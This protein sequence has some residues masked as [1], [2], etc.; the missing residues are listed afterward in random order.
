MSPSTDSPQDR[1]TPSDAL[2][3]VTGEHHL[4]PPVTLE[5]EPPSGV[6]SWEP[7]AGDFS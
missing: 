1:P 5:T 3:P 6:P 2:E 7:E 4:R